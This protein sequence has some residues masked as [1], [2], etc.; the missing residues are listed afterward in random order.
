MK[1]RK[2]TSKSSRRKQAKAPEE[3]LQ[4]LK[5]YIQAMTVCP[6]SVINP[7]AIRDALEAYYV[8]CEEGTA[9]YLA[10]P[11]HERSVMLGWANSKMAQFQSLVKW[12]VKTIEDE[13]NP[14]DPRVAAFLK[15][16]ELPDPITMHLHTDVLKTM[17]VMAG[18]LENRDLSEMADTVRHVIDHLNTV[19]QVYKRHCEKERD[20]IVDLYKQMDAKDRK[21]EELEK[22]LKEAEMSKRQAE[23]SIKEDSDDSLECLLAWTEQRRTR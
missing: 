18:L 1:G 19:A 12:F 3:V 15:M 21:I 4:Y 22:K 10:N 6:G 17:T 5:P 23:R 13:A 14:Q 2:T 20:W 8:D 16:F 7:G 9:R 11:K